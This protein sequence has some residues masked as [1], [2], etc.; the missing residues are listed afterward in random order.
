M[1]NA[2]PQSDIVIA[3]DVGPFDEKNLRDAQACIQ[4]GRESA[5]AAINRIKNDLELWDEML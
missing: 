4:A 5:E 1:Q 3:P 2:L